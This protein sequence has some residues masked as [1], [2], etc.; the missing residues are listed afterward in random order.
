[1]EGKIASELADNFPPVRHL[2]LGPL[3]FRFLCRHLI[4]YLRL[5]Q[6]QLLARRPSLYQ[7][8]LR[9][10][11]QQHSAVLELAE[12][13]AALVAP[14]AL[15]AP[16]SVKRLLSLRRLRD[17]VSRTEGAAQRSGRRCLRLLRPQVRV[18]PR[19]A[20]AGP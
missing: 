7:L 18:R 12:Q 6:A 2:S 3:R 19:Q 9:A 14:G 20:R 16:A 4:R 15:G 11:S 10:L 8:P 5:S 17:A 1:M 13:P